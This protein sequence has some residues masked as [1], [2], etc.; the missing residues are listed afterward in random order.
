MKERGR[1]D[2]K[3]ERGAAGGE[4]RERVGNQC[5]IKDKSLCFDTITV[6]QQWEKRTIHCPGNGPHTTAQHYTNTLTEPPEGDQHKRPFSIFPFFFYFWL[7][8]KITK[9]TPK[10]TPH[11]LL[12][13]SGSP[14]APSGAPVCDECWNR[15]MC[16][17]TSKTLLCHVSTPGPGETQQNTWQPPHC[18]I[19]VTH[20]GISPWTIWMS[21]DWLQRD[22]KD[23][24]LF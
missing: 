13:W 22:K 9:R 1:H 14:R 3:R 12:L 2:S 11:V 20:L 10:H 15:W 6:T 5:L 17:W 23:N 19:A 4:E 16:V 18:Q 7:K 8:Y 21:S 24:Q